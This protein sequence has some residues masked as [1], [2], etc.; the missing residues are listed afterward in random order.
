[1]SELV[2]KGIYN[3]ECLKAASQLWTGSNEH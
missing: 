2:I 1:M 3:T